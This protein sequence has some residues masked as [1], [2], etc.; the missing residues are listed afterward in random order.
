VTARAAASAERS[1]RNQKRGTAACDLPAGNSTALHRY[2]GIR[3]QLHLAKSSAGF[4]RWLS[5]R[6]VIQNGLDMQNN[7]GCFTKSHDVRSVQHFEPG[8]EHCPHACCDQLLVPL[9]HLR[10][11]ARACLTSACAACSFSRCWFP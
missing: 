9:F 1:T 8:H 11:A 3:H 7:S 5:S 10:C 6:A 4:S 2:Q